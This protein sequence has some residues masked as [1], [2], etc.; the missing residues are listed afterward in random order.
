MTTSDDAAKRLHPVHVELWCP[1]GPDLPWHVMELRGEEA[2]ARPFEFELAL[3]CEDAGADFEA[4]LGADAELLIERGGLSRICYGVIV[5]VEVEVSVLGAPEHQGVRVRLRLAP[6]FRLLEQEVD[7]RFHAGQTALEILAERLGEGLARY[8]RRVDFESRIAGSYDRRDYCVQFRESTFD[9]CSRL[10]EEEGIAYVFVPDSGG[11]RE[12]MVLVDN[13]EAY[14]AVELLAP[15]PLT[16]VSHA[17]DEL[18]HESL[19]RLDWRGRRTP[20]RVLT[21]GYNYKLPRRV[22]E[23]IAEAFEHHNPDVRK[24][25]LD[26]ERRQIIDD[27]VN[28]PEAQTFDGSGLDQRGRQA[29]VLLQGLVVDGNVGRGHSNATGFAAGGVF[30]LAEPRAPLESELLLIGVVHQA[31]REDGQPASYTYA[32]RFECVPRAT[33][34]RPALRTLKPRVHGVQ[35]GVVV[36]PGDDEVH[37]DALGRV[38][39]RFHADRRAGSDEQSSCWIRVAQVWAGP[40]YGAMVIPRVGMEVVVSFVDGNPDCPLITGCVYNG[41]NAPPRPLPTELSRSTFKSSS[42]P[43]G[44]GFNELM[45]EDAKGREQIFVHAQRRMDTRVRTAAYETVG[46]NKELHVGPAGDGET[47]SGDFNSMIRHNL[48]ERVEGSRYELTGEEQHHVRGDVFE[49]LANHKYNAED[50]ALNMVNLTVGVSGT[51]G[52]AANNLVL[53]GSELLSMQAG[54]RVV[55]ESNNHLDLKVGDSFITISHAGIDIVGPMIR[56]NSGGESSSALSPG[57]IGDFDLYT[58][59][60]ADVAD[61]GRPG[62]GGGASSGRSAKRSNQPITVNPHEVPPLVPPRKPPPPSPAS[63]PDQPED[64]RALIGIAW[65]K[66]EVWCSVATQL[67]GGFDRSGADR[68]ERLVLGDGVDGSELNATQSQLGTGLTF[69]VPVTIQ[70]LLPRSVGDTLESERPIVATLAGHRTPV[71]VQ[72]KFLTELPAYRYKSGFGRF[73]VWMENGAGYI[74]GTIPFVRGWMYY[75]VDLTDFVDDMRGRIGGKINGHR[76]WWYAKKRRGEEPLKGA[77]KAGD[78]YYWDGNAWLNVPM[79]WASPIGTRCLGFAVWRENGE[80]K[81]Q[82]GKMPWPDPVPTDWPATNVAELPA[83]LAAWVAAIENAWSEKFKLKRV[84]CHAETACCSHQLFCRADFEEVL[85]KERGV[86]VVAANSARANDSAWRWDMD[87]DTAAHEFGHHLGNPDEYP[88]AGTVDPT[89]NGDGATAGIDH[90]GLM[91]G[92]RTVR[93]RYFGTVTLAFGLA[94]REALGVP[95]M[96]NFKVQ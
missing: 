33:P 5:E 55:I 81:T 83:K 69:S 15:E 47:D 29:R 66:P 64:E 53:S 6:A 85:V 14:A 26:G 75:I 22:D 58:P 84:T 77:A 34:F 93:S 30:E 25:A 39:V 96:F 42:T 1:N 63:K 67:V 36:G 59:V 88:G 44:D 54:E 86:I 43:G 46:A 87:D 56:L 76:N 32:N 17:P 40:G 8:G 92:G 90:D 79:L 45:V 13:N 19:L 24:F 72:L 78:L 49:R 3:F 51:S 95:F 38:R 89:V 82:Y 18:D 10:M 73:S 62:G 37:T 16:I 52:H 74:G 68:T 11:Q 91:G 21:R 23:G 70:G 65:S 57:K 12:L 7:T 20:N 50:A 2:L 60:Y 80:V 41:E 31:K 35:T 94:A 71:P 48:N 9:F 61:D 4:A 28:D 27:P